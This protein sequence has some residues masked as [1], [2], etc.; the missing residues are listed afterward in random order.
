[1]A[2]L[3]KEVGITRRRSRCESVVVG[4]LIAGGI[5][6]LVAGIV[7]MIQANTIKTSEQCQPAQK[8]TRAIKSGCGY[9]NEAR[10]SGLERFLFEAQERFYE[11][12][13]HKIAFKPGVTSTEIRQR[14]KSYD[15]TPTQIKFVTDEIT[16][17]TKRLENMNISENKLA[18]REKRAKA[19]LSHW[20]RHMFPFG[21]P[22]AYD[23]YSGDWLMGPN[24]FCW[25]SICFLPMD[26]DSALYHFQPSTAGE[27]ET[28]RDKLMEINQTFAQFVKNM[29]LGV[30]A[31][32]VRTVE[33][34]KAGLDGLRKAFRDVDVNGPAGILNAKYMKKILVDGFL[35][36]MKTSELDL[37][38]IKQGK[39]VNESLR[40]F[41]IEYVGEPIQRALRYIEKE[42]LQYCT[43]SNLSS[44][45]ASLPLDY[46]YIN[47]TKTNKTTTKT[48]PTGERLDGKATYLKLLQY[49]TTTEKTPDEIFKLGWS[50]I[51]RNYPKVINLARRV[52]QE[53]DSQKAK[54][55]FIKILNRSEMFYNTEDIPKN[56]S[57]ATAHKLCSSIDGAKKYCPVRWN[58]MQNWFAHAREIMA[59]LH[60]KTID[61]FH[62]TGPYQ[63]TPNCPVELLPDFNPSSAA[64]TFRESDSK[65]SFPSVYSIPFFLQRFGPKNEEWTINAHEATPGHYT[66]SQGYV[67]HFQNSCRGP[68]SWI[69]QNTF[70]L[71]FSEGWAL[72][73]ENPLISKYT[74][75]YRD[76]PL[77]KYGMLKWQIW[78]ALRLVVDTGLHFKGKS[79]DWALKLFADYAWDTSDKVDKEVTRYQSIPGQAVT[80]M[81]GQLSI[82]ELKEEAEKVLGEKFNLK[83]FHFQVLRRGPSPL[84]YLK[85]SIRKYIACAKDVNSQPDCE[86]FLRAPKDTE[87]IMTKQNSQQMAHY[88]FKIF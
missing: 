11:L 36:K 74:D 22:F 49:F 71:E 14:Y 82:K 6:C 68:I 80:Y 83:D 65:C 54:G 59:T 81:L 69:Q 15:S 48:L 29:K 66:Q 4:G 34:C 5:A 87:N 51:N 3:Y 88:S 20:M 41:V 46:V 75:T 62:F 10:S 70:Y 26:V 40:Q 60:P 84:N 63:S 44:G 35:S 24:I 72:Y 67:E 27:M 58:A 45:L 76:D 30:A 17:L 19:Q 52:T 56:E 85:E 32:M 47:G 8:A 78:R 33:E 13:P 31:G 43:P 23:Y 28:L 21:V 73:A 18:L 86:D 1:M 16:K 39:S 55:E 57:D 61:L 64:P 12:L 53:N 37:W 77:T 2:L 50:I 42:H 25:S 38:R 9:S 7:L 79:R